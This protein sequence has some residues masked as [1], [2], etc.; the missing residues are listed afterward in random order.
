MNNNKREIFKQKINK[1]L[2]LDFITS[3][4]AFLPTGTSGVLIEAV[5]DKIIPSGSLLDLG[6]GIGVVGISLAKLG[7]TTNPLY[8]SDDS[9]E[10]I[11]LTKQNAANHNITI[12]SRVG[13]LYQPWLDMQFDYIIDDVSGISEEIA[14][15]SPWFKNVPCASG[16]DGTDLVVSVLKE[17][18]K[19]L[20]ENGK[21]FFP[22]LSLSN[23]QRIIDTAKKNFKNVNLLIRKTWPLPKEMNNHLETVRSLAKNDI[24]EIEEKFGMIMW[25]TDIYEANNKL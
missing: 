21:I 12:D 19:Y 8:L 20:K 18:P 25:H 22:V 14:K 3:D 10:A 11:K 23:G 9:E 7:K 16:I 1:D 5:K 4:K 2:E 13:S 24:I 17:A 6:C 15:I